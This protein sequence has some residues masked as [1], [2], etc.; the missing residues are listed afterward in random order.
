MT[1]K[2][3]SKAVRHTK[4]RAITLGSRFELNLKNQ[5]CNM[6]IMM[7]SYVKSTSYDEQVLKV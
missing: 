2:D 3:I 4:R 7:T 6:E 5:S 1:K